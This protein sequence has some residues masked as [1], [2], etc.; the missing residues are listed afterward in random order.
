MFFLE[1]LTLRRIQI[2]TQTSI[3]NLATILKEP[4]RFLE[5][6]VHHIPTMIKHQVH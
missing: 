6:T 1:I 2:H 4:S 5:A 3:V